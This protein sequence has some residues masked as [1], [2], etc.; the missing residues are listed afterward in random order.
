MHIF[1]VAYNPVLSEESLAYI[2][3]NVEYSM[4]SNDESSRQ[5]DLDYILSI[6]KDELGDVVGITETDY[7][8]LKGLMTVH[9]VNFIE[10]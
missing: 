6:T 4:I 8:S 1:K 7:E 9:N 2:V 5:Y 3:E 10:L